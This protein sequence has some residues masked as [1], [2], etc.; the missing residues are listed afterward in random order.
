MPRK[1]SIVF[2]AEVDGGVYQHAYEV[3]E[4]TGESQTK[5]LSRLIEQDHQNTVGKKSEFERLKTGLDR[6]MSML[7]VVL[8]DNQQIKLLAG[9]RAAGADVDATV[10]ADIDKSAITVFKEVVKL[11]STADVDDVLKV[12]QQLPEKERKKSN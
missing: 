7:L 2:R 9:A 12:L 10:A 5:Y 8:K 6:I 3:M 11:V 1:G 4:K